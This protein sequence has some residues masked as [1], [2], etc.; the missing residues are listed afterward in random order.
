MVKEIEMQMHPG[1][2]INVYCDN[3]SVVNKISSQQ[4]LQRTVNQH[5]HPDV[6]I[7][8]QVFHEV[9]LLETNIAI[10]TIRHVKGH[11]DTKKLKRSLMIEEHLNIEADAL[12]QKARDLPD[13][14]QY[15]PFPTNPVNFVLNNRYINSIYPWVVNTAFHSLELREYFSNKCG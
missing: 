6:H 1:T 7:E 4:E 8:M 12:N 15:H 13:Q 10:V 3:K 5:C 11:Q 9:S 14:R 2:K